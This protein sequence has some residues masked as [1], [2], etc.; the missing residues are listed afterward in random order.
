MRG[1]VEA[2][3]RY[4]ARQSSE[5]A[6]TFLP[7]TLTC[8]SLRIPAP[9]TPT[10]EGGKGGCM[11]APD[12]GKKRSVLHVVVRKVN[13]ASF[14]RFQSSHLSLSDEGRHQP[15]NVLFRGLRLS[16]PHRSVDR[17]AASCGSV[18][19]PARTLQTR[20]VAPRQGLADKV[21]RVF[22]PRNHG[23]MA[24]DSPTDAILNSQL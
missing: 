8:A 23:D 18:V 17:R 5:G 6:E 11:C 3:S 1:A 22:A 16:P 13:T 4:S 14:P 20:Q 12:S 2:S 10:G 19:Q 7:L 15:L 9:P 21:V 24:G